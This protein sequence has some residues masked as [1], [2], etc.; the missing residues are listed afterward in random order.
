MESYFADIAAAL[1]L[2]ILTS[3]SPC[4][5]TA[6][7]AAIA[8][9]G[10]KVDRKSQ[11]LVTGLMYTL[12]RMFTY[13][14]LGAIL[15][16]STELISPVSMF[17]QKHMNRMLGPVLILVGLFLLEVIRFGGQGVKVKPETQ[18]R[19]GSGSLT[20]AFLLGALF[21]LSFCPVSAGLFFGSTFAL[22]MKHQSMVVMPLSYG[23]G[24]AAPVVLF[25]VVIGLG[26][27]TVGSMFNKIKAFE[28]WARRISGVVFVVAGIY[29]SL[30]YIFHLF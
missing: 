14:V 21:A 20:G 4:P 6:N 27:G 22:A 13:V 16:S 12:G 1:W 5:L 24:T 17:L 19:L 10:K 2:G 3:I 29:L 26:I 11:V 30:T 15:V 8:F 18:Q 9:I 7:I 23:I 28:K 25:A